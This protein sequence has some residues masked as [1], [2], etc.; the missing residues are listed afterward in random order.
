MSI[1]NAKIWLEDGLY[2]GGLFVE[3]G[4]IAKIGKSMPEADHVMDAKGNL[5]LPGLV[6]LHVHFREPGFTHK[7]DFYTGSCA[8][9]AGGVTTVVDEPNNNPVTSTPDALRE[10]MSLIKRKAAVDYTFS[11]ALHADTLEHIPVFREMGVNC[12]AVFDELGDAPT[13]M[14][15]TGVLLDALSRVKEAEGLA[16]LNCRESDLVVHITERLRGSGSGTLDDYNAHFPHVAE[17]V[18]AAKRVLLSHAV[19][20]KTH[21]REVSTLETVNV[22]RKL[23]HYMVGVTAEARPDHLLLNHENTRG[24]GPY[25]Q[26]W[27]PVRRKTDNEALLGALR[28]GVIKVIASDHATHTEG[29]KERGWD[30][31]WKSPPGL[32]AV[33]TM[34]PLLLTKVNEGV[35]EL[36]TLIDAASANPAK[37]MGQFPRKGCIRVGSDADLVLVDMKMQRV[38]RGEGL[39]GKTKWTPFEGWRT[40]G[41]PVATYVRGVEAYVDGEA[42]AAPG[43]GVFLSAM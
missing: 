10:K 32:P 29:E 33:E 27:T 17:S 18:G 37:V 5:V 2:E 23:K 12:F 7:E 41:A 38:I 19:G 16:L 1:V 34:L 3:D 26:Q 8:A 39:H 42:V 25:A 9:V 40:R 6:D 30:D 21:M 15:D 20:V 13:G 22:L 35:L 14:D 31:I 4:K 28:D 43:H 11:V 24:L 36:G